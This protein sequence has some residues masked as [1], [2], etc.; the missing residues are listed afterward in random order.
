MIRLRLKPSQ[1]ICRVGACCALGAAAICLA[2]ICA[3]CGAPGPTT[4][5]KFRDMFGMSRGDDEIRGLGD[6]DPVVRR[7]S[8]QRLAARG[9]VDFAPEIALLVSRKHEE[10][11]DARIAAVAALRQ[12]GSR[13]SAA[14]LGRNLDDP[15]PLVRRQVILTLGALGGPAQVPDLLK[16]VASKDEPAETRRAAARAVG[17]I[18]AEN[19]VSG[20]IDNLEDQDQS[21]A[22][23][24]HE[25]LVR[26]S[27]TDLGLKKAPWRQWWDSLP[28]APASEETP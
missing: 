12:L 17:D 24:V 4:G 25:A 1:I 27:R 21:V 18:G 7:W 20:L 13:E 16:V 23:A 9:R 26:L 2:A 5:Q 15:N 8:I 3:G 22:A 6:D 11:P 28:Q 10:S 19:A 14:F